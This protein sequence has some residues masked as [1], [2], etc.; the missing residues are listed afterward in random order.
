MAA[1]SQGW[2][3]KGDEGTVDG[4]TILICDLNREGRIKGGIDDRALVIAAQ[5]Q[6]S[7]GGTGEVGEAK[8]LAGSARRGRDGK[9]SG[10][11]ISQGHEV[12]ATGG[13]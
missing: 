6:E 13:I 9:G 8:A 11:R 10:D 7:T 1:G 4:V 2:P 12:G 5:N 3:I